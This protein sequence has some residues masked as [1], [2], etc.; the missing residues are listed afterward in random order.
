MNTGNDNYPVAAVR[1]YTDAEILASHKRMDNAMC[2]YAFCAE[3]SIKN[4][5]SR[6]PVS[7]LKLGHKV[8]EN[9]EDIRQFFNVL[10]VMDAKT[11]VILGQLSLPDR[12]FYHHPERRY[13]SDTVYREG[14]VKAAADFSEGLIKE[15]VLEA[16]DGRIEL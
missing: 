11:G 7:N 4:L 14:E 16:L 13:E 3:C 9:W 10:E 8:S 5:Y 15:I 6:M 2:H 12:L 1:H